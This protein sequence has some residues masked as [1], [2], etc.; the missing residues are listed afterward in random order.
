[1]QFRWILKQKRKRKRAKRMKEIC[2]LQMS[3]GHLEECSLSRWKTAES[4]WHERIHST[5]FLL[6]RKKIDVSYFSS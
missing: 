5:S 6:R 3:R 2:A 4:D 1:M